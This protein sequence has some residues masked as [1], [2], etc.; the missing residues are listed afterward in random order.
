VAEG[1]FEER[2]WLPVRGYRLRAA[3]TRPREAGPHPA[4]LYLPGLGARSLTGPLDAA[5]PRDGILLL[6]R[7]FSDAGFVTLRA[8]P[9][10][11][12]ESEGP[13]FADADLGAEIDGHRAAL[14]ELLRSPAV[15][16]ARVFLFGHSLGGVLAPLIAGQS[17]PRDRLAGVV[18]YGTTSRPW[19]ECLADTARRQ[20]ALSTIADDQVL[21]ESERAARLYR[22]LLR[23]GSSFARVI[24]DHPDLAGCVAASDVRE[25]NL[26]GRSL[27]YWR[28]LERIDLEQAWRAVG[29]PVLA[30][31]GEHDW[32]V[33][34]D[35][36]R[37]I[38]A[39]RAAAGAR[40][41]T[42]VVAGLDHDLQ[43]H[44][45]LIASYRNRGRGVADA[46]AAAVAVAWM[47]DPPAGNMLGSGGATGDTPA[48]E[49]SNE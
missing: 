12:G 27:D 19:S 16:P 2:G 23:A 4:I 17:A 26:H 41:S 37:R 28:K 30:L 3:W 45:S 34:A 13:A 39:F 38:A 11:V 22:E 42:R 9:S 1:W 48:P 32:V 5:P 8:D 31:H 35:D 44:S 33:S 47:R 49:A 46:A 15:D 18:V 25:S 43:R 20:L 6:L 14:E 7:A 40:T 29:A 36:P 21:V 24:T 10:G